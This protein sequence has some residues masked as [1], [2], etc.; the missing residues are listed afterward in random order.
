MLREEI[1]LRKHL[2]GDC[3]LLEMKLRLNVLKIHSINSCV[4]SP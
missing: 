2:S 4:F 3:S 1:P